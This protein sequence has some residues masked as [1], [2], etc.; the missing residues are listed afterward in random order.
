MSEVTEPGRSPAGRAVIVGASSGVGRA[1]AETLAREGYDL[2]LSA[3]D[4]RDLEVLAADLRLRDRIGVHVHT[5]DLSEPELAT[6]AFIDTCVRELGRVDAIFLTAGMIHSRDHG[7]GEADT[8]SSLIWVNYANMIQLIAGFARRFQEQAGGDIVTFSS[9]AAAAPR[10][11]NVVYSSA[12]AGLETYC[13][14]LRHH[15][16]GTGV[17]LQTYALGY[18]DTAMSYGQK[19]LFPVASPA[20][21]AD[22]V[23]R[24]L[25]R[26]RGRV[27]FPRF[28]LPIV[29]VLRHLPWSLYKRLS[30]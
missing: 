18:V 21:V 17:T 16:D 6:A 9:I 1:L 24:N 28:W 5:I 3:R 29:L 12:K 11:R 10:G 23:V 25:G 8:I 30:F 14:G 19:L 20:K 13:R 26:D 7:P 2:L 15:L 22:Y 4:R 27:Y